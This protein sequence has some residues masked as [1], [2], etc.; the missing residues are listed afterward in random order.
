MTHMCFSITVANEM[1]F[2]SQ[3]TLVSYAPLLLSVSVFAHGQ[4]GHDKLQHVIEG[5]CYLCHSDLQNTSFLHR[6][7][8]YRT[9]YSIYC[10]VPTISS[11][12]SW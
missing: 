11:H 2:H 6:E 10:F 12:P 9:Y 5:T 3:A 8:Y 4:E 1:S 7:T